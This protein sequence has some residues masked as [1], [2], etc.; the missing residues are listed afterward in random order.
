MHFTGIVKIGGALGNDPRPLLD[1]LSAR[2]A[3]GERWALVHGASGIM[4]TLAKACGLQ[5]RYVTSPS[6]YR[7]RFLGE[8]ER[9]LFVSA[10]LSVSATL[11]CELFTRGV[12]A[13][14]LHPGLARSATGTR[15]EAL[16]SVEDGR[17]RILHGNT[18]GTTRSVDPEALRRAWAMGTV[19]LLPPLALDRD[20]AGLL[21]V[22]GDRLAAAAAAAVR[23]D[24]LVI[25][26]NVPGLLAD[27]ADPE[28]LVE[29]AGLEEWERLENM[30]RGNMKRKLLACREALEGGLERVCIAD[31]RVDR[32]LSRALEGRGT[33]L[34][35]AVYTE[36]A[37]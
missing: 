1:D 20:G 37:V 35:Q 36:A 11:S 26:S 12:R 22:D 9:D 28:S 5:P 32:P 29:R 17:V 3:R 4:D 19:P 7:S 24:V 27:P 25:L 31:S 16:R 18:S 2:V 15:K 14:V 10:A 6:G 8:A 30:A 13:S 34:C 33:T 21:N 23:A